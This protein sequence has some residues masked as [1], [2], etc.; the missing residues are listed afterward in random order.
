MY[1]GKIYVADQ[2]ILVHVFGNIIKACVSVFSKGLMLNCCIRAVISNIDHAS[3]NGI[4]IS[5]LSRLVLREW[6]TAVPSGTID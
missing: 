1:E 4:V 3:L 5:Q 2:M 6:V